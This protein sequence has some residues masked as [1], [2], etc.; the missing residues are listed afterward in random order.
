MKNNQS[1]I[2]YIK[3]KNFNNMLLQVSENGGTKSG[4]AAEERQKSGKVAEERQSG[5]RAAEDQGTCQIRIT[6]FT[7]YVP[8]KNKI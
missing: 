7:N 4:K 5:R 8:N 2:H 3:Y 1:T 6:R